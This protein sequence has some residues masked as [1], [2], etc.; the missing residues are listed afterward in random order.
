MVEIDFKDF[1]PK[2]IS[3]NP[4]FSAVAFTFSGGTS[5]ATIIR[6]IVKSAVI[7]RNARFL[8][9]ENKRPEAGGVTI[10]NTE[11]NPTI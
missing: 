6:E 2:N 7:V 9:V 4:R 11:L 3:L 10:A 8:P 1:N 5:I